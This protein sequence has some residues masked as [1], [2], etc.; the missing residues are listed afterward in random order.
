MSLSVTNMDM[1]MDRGM[2][3]ISMAIYLHQA[4]GIQ[5]KLSMK[6]YNKEEK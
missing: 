3:M 1:V 4:I 6:V 2:G 5:R